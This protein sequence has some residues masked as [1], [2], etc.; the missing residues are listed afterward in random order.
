MEKLNLTSR[1][2]DEK[3]LTKTSAQHIKDLAGHAIETLNASINS[4]TFYSETMQVIGSETKHELKKGWDAFQI[5]DVSTI[6]EQIGKLQSLQ[7]WLGEAIKAKT[8]LELQ[9]TE[10][11]FRDWLSD[12]E[13]K[14]VSPTAPS[15]MSEEDWL[16]SLSV[17]ERNRYLHL[18]TMCAIYGK[19]IH[20]K[21][22]FDKAR[23]ELQ[24]VLAN[25]TIYEGEGQNI[26]LRTRT[27]SV[28]PSVVDSEYFKLQQQH[29]Q[30]QA[31]FNGLRHN[32]ELVRD[33]KFDEDQAAY[34]AKRE[35]YS[36]E[37]SR[38]YAQYTADKEACLRTV[39]DLK[40]IIPNDLKETY[41]YISSLGK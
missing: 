25:P 29:R 11:T 22:P 32:F 27:H 30:Y 14:L 16:N 26:I 9:V 18:Q 12:N 35:E 34:E 15:H 1:F 38:L 7:A 33:T 41:D 21:M 28:I 37:H 31:E 3:G 23:K 39:R 40:V 36:K 5:Q 24:N 6:L 8:L 13:I 19:Y 20:P 17:K 2:L 10:Y 4:I